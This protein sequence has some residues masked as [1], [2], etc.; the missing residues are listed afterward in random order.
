MKSKILLLLLSVLSLSA[1]GQKGVQLHGFYRDVLPGTVQKGFDESGQP[2][3]ARKDNSIQYFL[4]LSAPAGSRITPVEIWI[5]GQQYAA[6][7]VKVATPVE[8]PSSIPG[9]KQT[10]LGKT[11]G[12]V[13]QVQPGAALHQVRYTKA[14][15]KAASNEVVVVY[16]L[17]GV[18][19]SATLKELTKLEP[20][21]NE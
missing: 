1:F 20:Q 10:L 6:K 4:Y 13:Y 18:Y 15:D 17:N 2:Q 8:L 3:A 14:R 5:H 21:N 12:A 9:K 19:Y 11:S 7:A 16:K